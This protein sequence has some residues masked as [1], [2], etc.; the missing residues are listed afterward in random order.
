VIA[1]IL[2]K[3]TVLSKEFAR[4]IMKEELKMIMLKAANYC[5]VIETQAW[6]PAGLASVFKA[7][8]RI[9]YNVRQLVKTIHL[10]EYA[11]K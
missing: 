11:E 1:N 7:I 2:A 6:E 9:A 4:N 10:G 3:D 8:D 5:C